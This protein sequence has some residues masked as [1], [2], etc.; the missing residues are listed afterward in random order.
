MEEDHISAV[1]AK[2]L[3]RASL[4]DTEKHLHQQGGV[5]LGREQQLAAAPRR[6]HLH[7]K[8][9]MDGDY[10]HAASSLYHVIHDS[11][12]NYRSPPGMVP[13]D[14]R[15]FMQ[16]NLLLLKGAFM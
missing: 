7:N 8:Q 12:I 14:V 3:L 16:V 10:Y 15:V 5:H 6:Q 4:P 11:I 9:M 2:A 13:N 1:E